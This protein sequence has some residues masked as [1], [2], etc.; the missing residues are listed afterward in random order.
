MS[1][2]S[3]VSGSKRTI[4][5]SVTETTMNEDE[6]F[7]SYAHQDE[8]KVRQILEALR[9][10]GFPVFVDSDMPAGV[11]W[12]NVLEA[13]LEKAYAVVV[14]WSSHSVIKGGKQSEWIF[15][16]ASIGLKKDR[17]F[18]IK[19]ENGITPPESF[20]NKHAAD[21]SDWNGD[22]KDEK[23]QNAIRLLTNLWTAQKGLLKDLPVAKPLHFKTRPVGL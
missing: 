22:P 8:P 7:L 19:I 16:E 12:E 20:K 5:I 2:V 3:A 15:R 14:V 11:E 9:D 21:L 13:E 17:L 10:C 18:P 1:C 6:I 23:F 4:A